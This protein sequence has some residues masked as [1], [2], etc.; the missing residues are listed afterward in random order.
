MS[1]QNPTIEE[2]TKYAEH[3]IIYGDMTKAYFNAFP[4]ASKKIQTAMPKASKLHKHD[5]IQARINELTEVSKK[6]SEEEFGVTTTYLKKRLIDAIDA[7]LERKDRF[8]R[9]S[10]GCKCERCCLCY[11]R[12]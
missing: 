3:F 1:Q 8:T 2:A 9:Q 4:N 5:K 12:T 11:R 6:A 7:G 10:N